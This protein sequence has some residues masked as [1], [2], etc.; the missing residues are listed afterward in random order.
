MQDGRSNSRSS[1]A[2]MAAGRATAEM[3]AAQSDYAQLVA[4]FR[5]SI[6]R[7]GIG[8]LE[9]YYWYHTVDLGNGLVT[10]GDYDFRDQINS[11][12]FPED[13]RG[14][15]VLDIGSATG[16]FAFEFEKRGAEV[17]SVELPSLAEWDMISGERGQ[18]VNHMMRGHKASTPEEAY[19]RHLDGPFRFCHKMLGSKVTRCYSSVCDLTL[20]KVGGKKFE[21][22]YAGD[23]LLHLFSP[24]K[25]LDTLSTLC[26]G[27]IFVTLDVPFQHADQPYMRFVGKES[28][29]RTWWLMSKLCLENMLKRVGFRTVTQVGAYSGIL[30]RVGVTYQR[31]VLMGSG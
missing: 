6:R 8:G 19:V 14:K 27:Q 23:I 15:R 25:A 21:L 22:I 3:E 16:Y 1:P 18:I 5:E 26:A 29:G 13:L 31:E 24:L 28:E 12:G 9:N 2:T 7:L 17:V 20:D 11:F 4:T 10:P 30:R